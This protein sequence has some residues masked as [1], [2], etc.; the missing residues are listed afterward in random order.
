MKII[1]NPENWMA[2][3]SYGLKAPWKRSEGEAK[4]RRRDRRKI[5]RQDVTDVVVRI[6]G[7][8]GRASPD[9]KEDKWKLKLLWEETGS[10]ICLKFEQHEG[11]KKSIRD[12]SPASCFK[13]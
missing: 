11:E 12:I 9:R 1:P 7:G 2:N 6:R 4:G 3:H 13:P 10:Q 5:K 8:E